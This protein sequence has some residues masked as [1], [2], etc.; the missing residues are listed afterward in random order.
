MP[1]ERQHY[2]PQVYLKS[3]EGPVRSLSDRNT[4]FNGVYIFDKHDISIGDGRTRKRIL[5]E[6]NLY[7]IDF[8]NRFI[9][10][11][12]PEI[13]LDFAKQTLDIL[14]EK[15][16]YAS[17]N[18][19]A[20]SSENAISQ[21][22]NKLDEWSFAYNGNGTLNDAGIRTEIN[23]LKSYVIESAFDKYVENRWT[24]TLN[25]FL[26]FADSLPY[27][28]GQIEY[29]YPSD[30]IPIKMLEMFVYMHSRN[31][32][33]DM[34]GLLPLAMEVMLRPFLQEFEDGEQFIA[35]MERNLWLSG[36]YN[37]LNKQ[38]S[39]FFHSF[40]TNAYSRLG[41][42]LFKI[43][44]DEEGYFITSDNPAFTYTSFVTMNNSNGMYFPLSPRYLL[45]IGKNTADGTTIAETL[46]R[47]IRNKDIRYINR[48]IHASATKSIISNKK[49]LGYIM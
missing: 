2:V 12:N 7:T 24:S 25:D 18:G 48:I 10:A 47:T 15:N 35:E 31:P 8:S 14:N 37:G 39:G 16:A 36:I 44:D 5:F 42:V 23:A 13:V 29:H 32:R 27:G 6:E 34:L 19:L 33:F 40:I 11:W 9:G 41:L 4:V 30:E 22:F 38:N 21:H 43:V 45:F 26:A 49:H 28:H 3:W 46:I 20:L 17:N 1:Q